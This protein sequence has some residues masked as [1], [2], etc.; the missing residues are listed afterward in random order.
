MISV[1]K[2]ITTSN[3]TLIKA[4]LKSVYHALI[5]PKPHISSAIRQLRI[6]KSLDLKQY[7]VQKRRLPYIVCAHFVPSFRKKDH[8]A[9][10][11]YFILDVDHISE[12]HLDVNQLKT[13]IIEDKRVVLCFVSPG[14]DGLKI[15]FKLSERCYDSGQYSIFYKIFANAFSKEYHLEQVID[16]VTSDVSRA[17]FISQDSTAYYNAE[18]ELID[19]EHFVDLNNVHELREV[20]HVINKKQKELQDQQKESV[21]KEVKIVDPDGQTMD[22]I[23]ALLNPKAVRRKKQKNFYVPEILNTVMDD[24]VAYIERTGVVVKG[25]SNISYG[26]KIECQMGLKMSETNLF[27]GKKGFS[28]VGSPKSGTDSELNIL[29][30]DVVNSFLLDYGE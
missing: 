3:E 27:F 21:S 17:C 1:G 18:A 2:N 8:F 29:M 12:K 16:N 4:P 11:E 22:S 10:T 15:V 20:E 5:N 30:V 9:Y 23:K 19:F 28:V 25:V 7:Q 6:I 26:K 14:G 24:L 13:K